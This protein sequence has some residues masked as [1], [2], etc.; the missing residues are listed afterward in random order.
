MKITKSL[1]RKEEYR[2]MSEQDLNQLIEEYKFNLI[3]LNAKFGQTRVARTTM[4][5]VGFI[6]VNNAKELRKEIARIY[7]ILRERQ[8][9]SNQNQYKEKEVTKTI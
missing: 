4:K 3:L 8:L 5:E 2:R 1:S 9:L 7:T 6:G